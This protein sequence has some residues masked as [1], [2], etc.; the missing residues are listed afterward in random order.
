MKNDIQIAQEAKLDSIFDIAKKLGVNSEEIIPYGYT[1]AKIEPKQP[2]PNSKLILVTS[3]NPTKSGEGKSTITIALND[4][5]CRIGKK[6]VVALREPSLGP[7]F[8]LKGGATGG[9]YA[10]VV[11]ME[12]INLH[13]TG[14]FHAI[15][16][17][18]NL[19]SSCIDNHIYHGNKLDFDLNQITWKRCLDLNDR[20]LRDITIG[21]GSKF[22]GQ[23]R[24]DGFYITVASEIMAIL[25][26]AIDLEDLESRLSKI[27]IGYNTKNEP[28]Y[29]KQLEIVGSILV[30]LKEAIKPNLVQTLENNPAL[31]HGGPFANIAHG[32]NSTIA[33]KTALHYGDYVVTE[34]GFGADLGAEKFLNIKCRAAELKPNA[35]VIVVTIKALKNHSENEENILALKEGIQNM[36]KH[37]ESI[38]AFGLPFVIALNKF[39]SDTDEELTILLDYCSKNNYPISI[40]EG[41]EKGS[42][43]TIDLANKVISLCEEK[44]EFHYLYKLENSI[45]EK[46]KIIAS[47]V[48]GADDVVYSDNALQKLIQIKENGWDTL[49]ICVAKTPASLSD[50]PSLIGRPRNFNINVQ[51]FNISLGAGFIVVICGNIMRMPG[52]PKEPAAKKI[53]LNNNKI[54]GLF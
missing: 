9:G 2:N 29:L 42:L 11:P 53:N 54:T 18:N 15:T 45:A 8:G 34:A 20:S 50:N 39:V 10:Q 26:L 22:N 49:P 43:G 5:L 12:E 37:I 30:L 48:Y 17:A 38:Q 6:S 3:I 23:E 51:D 47:T 41:W 1:K 40:C 4:G 46:I 7:V 52:L 13:F 35:V 14:D 16:S 25:C 24:K 28:I 32:C 21:Q 33:T 36:Q 31:I 44:N 27:L 19:I